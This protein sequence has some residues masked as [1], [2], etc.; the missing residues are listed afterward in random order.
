MAL[1]G[2]SRQARELLRVTS[3][4]MI[5]PMYPTRREGMEALLAD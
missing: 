1:S 2:V 5:F 3:L 4:D